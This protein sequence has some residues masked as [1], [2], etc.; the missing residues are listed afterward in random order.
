MALFSF[1]LWL[2]EGSSPG[3]Q[4]PWPH[5]HSKGLKCHKVGEVKVTGI[6]PKLPSAVS[7]S[8]WVA[9]CPSQPRYRGFPV[10]LINKS[11]HG[12]KLPQWMSI[13]LSLKFLEIVRKYS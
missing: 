9:A 12:N 5:Q 8:V 6:E 11:N 2:L 1:L 7:T 13:A 3:I 10:M 4:R